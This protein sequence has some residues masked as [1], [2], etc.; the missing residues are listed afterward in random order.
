MHIE[1]TIYYRLVA[2]TEW[3]LVS[4]LVIQ[5]IP[6]ACV[7]HSTSRKDF[8]QNIWYWPGIYNCP[9]F[10]CY[11]VIHTYKTGWC[12]SGRNLFVYLSYV[13][14]YSTIGWLGNTWFKTT[15][16]LKKSLTCPGLLFPWF[17]PHLSFFRLVLVGGGKVEELTLASN[18]FWANV[19]L[20]TAT[21]LVLSNETKK[22]YLYLYVLQW[23][24]FFILMAAV[25]SSKL[26][27][28]GCSDD[29]D[30]DDML[31]S[32]SGF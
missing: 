29:G 4:F 13:Q 11:I 20:T 28:W 6:Y 10:H 3:N 1:I 15:C 22:A 14:A 9:Y 25:A 17:R 26:A 5:N 30:G 24:L 18:I 12:I 27:E 7:F 8:F 23:H 32:C 31:K 2:F 21:E 19:V 16:C